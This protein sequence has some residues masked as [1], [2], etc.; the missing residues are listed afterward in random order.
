MAK[1]EEEVAKLGESIFDE[2]ILASS[3]VRLFGRPFTGLEIKVDEFKELAG[4]RSHRRNP[5]TDKLD[6]ELSPTLA[7][8]YGFSYEGNYYKLDAPYVFLV[9]GEGE[10]VEIPSNMQQVGVELMD[11]HFLD[12]V[13]MWGYDK[14]DFS[15]R[16]EIVSGWLEEILLDAAMGSS[17]NMTAGQVT[18]RV[19]LTSRVDMQQRVD[20]TSRVDLAMRSRF[21]R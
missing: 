15:I 12:G 6:K 4:K 11:E 8:I 14:V 1:D 2:T 19:D 3:H 18:P 10:A 17:S 7:R 16:I 9:H 20:L 21:K 5:L 13:R